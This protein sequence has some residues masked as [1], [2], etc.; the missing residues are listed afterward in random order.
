M[1]SPAESDVT[2]LYLVRHGATEAN[3][4][5]PYILQGHAIDLPLSPTGEGQARAVAGFLRQFP[6]GRVFSSTMIRARQTAETIARELGVAASVAANL[7]ECDVGVWEGLDWGTI[8]QRYPDEHRRFVENPAETPYLGGESY[9]DVLRRTKPVLE[10]LLDD[11]VGEH[12][13]V[14]SHNVVNRAFLA[15]LMGLDLRRAPK[16]VQGNCC[17]NLIRRRAGHTE[18]V[19]LN[20]V[21]HT[22]SLGTA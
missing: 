15:D 11:H 9:G 10:G 12:V 14:V 4:R 7:Q 13:A 22:G 18:L 3:Q 19:T 16:I 21:F 20:A 5:V 1:S 2:W 6:I 17:V 8:R